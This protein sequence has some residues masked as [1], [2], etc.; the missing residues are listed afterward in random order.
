MKRAPTRTLT[1]NLTALLSGAAI[2]AWA[3]CGNT[4]QEGLGSTEEAESRLSQENGGYSL[5]SEAPAFGEK[6]AFA[7]AGVLEDQTEVFDEMTELPEVQTMI[8]GQPDQAPG[9]RFVLV[10]VWGQPRF[11]PGVPRWTDWTGRISVSKGAVVARRT[12]RFEPPDRRLPRV[13]HRNL[14]FESYTRPHHDGLVVNI[15]D[16]PQS[17]LPVQGQVTIALGQLAPVVIPYDDLPGFR[18]L[19]TTDPLGNKL[20]IAAEE[21]PRDGCAAGFLMGRW[22][23]LGPNV[24]YFM[25]Q[26]AGPAGALHGHLAGIWGKK[27]ATGDQV[28]FG[29]YIGMQGHARGIL[30]GQYE[31]GHFGGRWLGAHGPVG[32][33]RGVYK[34]AIPGPET[35]G[36]FLGGWVQ[37]QCD[38]QP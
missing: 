28:F 36:F 25:G 30:A 8:S 26:W 11:D 20:F 12:I 4:G 5:E 23:R 18:M 1:R 33:L 31:N 37:T 27:P 14:P 21:I 29:K 35:G 32:L 19:V 22:H 6:D 24:G 9:R 38:A 13:D 10:A 17:T 2:L 34:E 16:N 15:Y 7:S 3:A